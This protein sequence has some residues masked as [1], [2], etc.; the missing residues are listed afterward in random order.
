MAVHSDGSIWPL[1]AHRA[2]TAPSLPY[3][4]S[5]DH[6]GMRTELS[7]T[8]MLNAVAKT[9]GA[10]A[11][12]AELEPGARI[13]MHL[14]WHWQRVVW[15]LAAWTAGAVIVE[16]G[17]A[18][19]CELVVA[20][21]ESA[22]AFTEWSEPWVVSMHPLGLVDQSLP[23]SVIDATSLCRMQP[24]ALLVEPA[25]GD[26]PALQ[27][28]DGTTVTRLEALTWVD[29]RGAADSRLLMNRR[30]AA[31]PAA[32][33]LPALHPLLGSGAVI[34]CDEADPELTAQREGATEVWSGLLADVDDA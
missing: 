14:P 2:R 21:F 9:A 34:L 12:E 23:S 4:T 11:A 32:W 16:Q 1:A 13:A 20:D 5:I 30:S 27:L 22:L 31:G 26:G 19:H 7:G 6:E 33:L 10:L 24:D 25:S 17:D 28:R 15:T 8:S 29:E 3:L 18:Q